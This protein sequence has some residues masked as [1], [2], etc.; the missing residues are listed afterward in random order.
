MAEVQYGDLRTINNVVDALKCGRSEEID[1]ESVGDLIYGKKDGKINEYAI[2][3]AA[4]L[5]KESGLAKTPSGEI[6]L[7]LYTLLIDHYMTDLTV[8]CNG[9]EDALKFFQKVRELYPKPKDA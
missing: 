1:V 9:R 5:F 6:A 3:A 8:G 2:N 7:R 4:A